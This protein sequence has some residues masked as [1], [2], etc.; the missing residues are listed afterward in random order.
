LAHSTFALF[1][2]IAT[3]K[4][5]QNQSQGLGYFNQLNLFSNRGQRSMIEITKLGYYTA[6]VALSDLV[7]VY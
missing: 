6:C 7:A 2:Y 4:Q 5:S 1:E 3:T